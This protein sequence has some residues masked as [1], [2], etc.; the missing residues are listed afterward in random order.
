MA[1]D[2]KE[3][4]EM[5]KLKSKG[6]NSYDKEFKASQ[7]LALLTIKSSQW[8]LADDKYEFD[9]IDLSKKSGSTPAK[10]ETK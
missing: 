2:K 6:E 9:G 4:P 5:V 10:A 8:E 1:T 3:K 7:A